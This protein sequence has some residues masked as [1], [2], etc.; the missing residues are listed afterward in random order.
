MCGGT[1]VDNDSPAEESVSDSVEVD[2]YAL[3]KEMLRK[4]D[5][6]DDEPFFLS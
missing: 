1:P 2:I 4:I 5:H 3:I 6:S